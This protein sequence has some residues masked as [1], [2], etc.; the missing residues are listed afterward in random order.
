[1]NGGI[2]ALVAGNCQLA[3]PHEPK[4]GQTAGRPEHD[5]VWVCTKFVPGP[6][7]CPQQCW[8]DW[9]AFSAAATIC[10]LG[11][12][13]PPEDIVQLAQT[14]GK[15]VIK[16][17]FNLE[18]PDACHVSLD[19]AVFEAILRELS[20]K[21]AWHIFPCK[22]IAEA[23]V[24]TLPTR[25]CPLGGG[26]QS[27]YKQRLNSSIQSTCVQSSMLATTHSSSCSG[28]MH[29]SLA[30]VAGRK[31]DHHVKVHQQHHSP[32]LGCVCR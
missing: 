11:P 20:H 24:P 17:S 30:P 23:K 15:R 3:S 25:I 8:S 1:M 10:R 16:T 14:R 4:E 9:K 5:C 2:I 29:S 27:T 13:D 6:L 22:Q 28:S 21:P 19:G 7:D 18:M 32:P 26:G 12:L 31:A